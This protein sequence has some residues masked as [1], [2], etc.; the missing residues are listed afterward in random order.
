[1]A[2]SNYIN[3]D[4]PLKDKDIIHKISVTTAN[5]AY[6]NGPIEGMHADINKKIY[7]ADMKIL[8]KLI[9]NRLA[10]IFNIILDNNKLNL[11]KEKCDSDNIEQQLA[12]VTMQY[13]FEEGFKKQEVI[14]ANLDN[15]D[16]NRLYDFMEFKLEVVLSIILRENKDDI[17]KF[18]AG[19]LLFG[20]SWD[21]ATPEVLTFKEFLE[22][23]E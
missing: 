6:R 8:N 14:I 11:I 23:L 15:N 1:M 21:Y 13:V 12:E 18:L 19:G 20:Q 4:D 5:Y 3:L 2:L 7:D 9:V 22:K 17:K 16:I 10:T